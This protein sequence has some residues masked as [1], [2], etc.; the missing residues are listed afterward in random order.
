MAYDACC[1]TA[2]A[3]VCRS[4]DPGFC[5]TGRAPHSAADGNRIAVNDHHYTWMVSSELGNDI[6]K[7]RA[8][9]TRLGCVDD[10]AFVVL[11]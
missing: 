4:H 3:I 1:E 7:M 9:Q 8:Q 11:H 6:A 10:D 5:G 2:P